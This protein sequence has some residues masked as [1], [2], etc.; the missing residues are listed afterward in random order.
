MKIYL[1]DRKEAIKNGCSK[2]VVEYE[3][4]KEFFK[5]ILKCVFVFALPFL[6]MLLSARYGF[7]SLGYFA[8]YII[9]PI[10]FYS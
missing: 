5:L 3:I 4:L 10:F 2:R 8:L 6:I 9:L 1:Y 7:Y